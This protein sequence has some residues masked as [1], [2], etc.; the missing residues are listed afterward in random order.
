MIDIK[1]PLHTD[2]DPAGE[3]PGDVLEAMLSHYNYEMD[4][5][6]VFDFD[7]VAEVTSYSVVDESGKSWTPGDNLPDSAHSVTISGR[8][9]DGY[10]FT[11]TGS[12]GRG[13]DSETAF[14][15]VELFTPSTVLPS[16]NN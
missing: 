15:E 13:W 7:D 4:T 3:H 1:Y 9:T 2:F 6:S 10:W 11:V 8:C 14:V 5:L 12:E 16:E